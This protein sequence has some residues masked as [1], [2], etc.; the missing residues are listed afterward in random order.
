MKMTKACGEC[1]ASLHVD[2]FKCRCGWKA[3]GATARSAP[4]ECAHKGC[5]FPAVIRME[6]ANNGLTNVCQKHASFHVEQ[7]ALAWCRAHG[8]NT[9]DDCIAYVR[10]LMPGIARKV[11]A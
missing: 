8:L 1:G 3:E 4:V 2:A 6:I 10:K 9:R 5:Q 11:G 7:E